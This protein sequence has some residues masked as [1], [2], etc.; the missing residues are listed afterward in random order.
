MDS[1][2]VAVEKFNMMIEDPCFRQGGLIHFLKK[3]IDNNVHPVQ[4]FAH[5]H[6]NGFTPDTLNQ[7]TGSKTI[8]LFY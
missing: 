2:S 7:I 6:F 4:I 1:I 5:H 3:R 8:H